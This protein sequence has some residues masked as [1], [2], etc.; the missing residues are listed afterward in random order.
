MNQVRDINLKNMRWIFNETSGAMSMIDILLAAKLSIMTM[1]K[2]SE[3]CFMLI[4]AA[5]AVF[6]FWI[7]T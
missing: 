5:T 6:S 4:S 7:M 2:A 1:A 3:E